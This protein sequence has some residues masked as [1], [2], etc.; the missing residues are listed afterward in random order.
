M[1]DYNTD[2][3]QTLCL[4]LPDEVENYKR[5]GDFAAANAAIDRFLSRPV[6]ADLRTRLLLEKEILKG[7]AKEF[8]Y[9]EEE[10][11]AL[12]WE[13]IP[14]FER[15]DL[16][17]L[18]ECGL[19]EW[20]YLDQEKPYI[21]SVL[22]NALHTDAEMIKRAGISSS[23]EK[24]KEDLAQEIAALRSEGES[25][26]R[27]RLRTS[28][29]L[30]DD[31]F[32]PGMYLKAQ[33][34]IPANLHQISNTK[35]ITRS[36][37]EMSV[38]KPDSLFRTICLE[39]RPDENREFY[40]EY[41]Y[42]VHLRYVDAYHAAGS[43]DQKPDSFLGEYL[44]EQ[45]PHIRF[46]PDLRSLAEEIL[47]KAKARTDL[48]KARAIYDYITENVKYSYMRS[49][50]LIP[51]IPQ[52]CARNLR[53]DCGVQAL[54]F[55][56]L[57]RIA[58]VPAKWQSGLYFGGREEVGAHD[59]A[60]FY[61]EGFGWLYA[62]PSF[63]GSAYREGDE[64][65]RE[66]YFG[67]LDPFRMAANNAFQQPFAKPKR[68]LPADPYDNQSGELESDSCGYGFGETVSRK[69]LLEATRL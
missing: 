28:I 9:T 61:A 65:R 69:T 32:S 20:I 64:E 48:E 21:H 15:K 27:F 46:T 5:A 6:A 50:F 38:D 11:I 52:Y 63:G 10:T 62:D 54:L 53:G 2:A 7:L 55:I 47:E 66:F 67:N 40:V 45:Y 39:D 26:W 58:N 43:A 23:D 31:L 60:M 13:R 25:S 37:G 49:Y 36:K 22:R 41:E 4:E 51:D 68:F 33:L 59:W 56:T 16:K 12:F 29:Q 19:A 1:S 8:P 34:P 17:R 42:T 3:L 14:D 30:R 57:C 35:I 24:E 44:S 18:D